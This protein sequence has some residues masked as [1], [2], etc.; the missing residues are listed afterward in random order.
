MPRRPR[1]DPL[2]P[3][4]GKAALKAEDDMFGCWLGR[5][6]C[7]FAAS[8]MYYHNNISDVENEAP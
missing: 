8:D 3:G 7:C 2:A 1:G 6:D 4:T 5:Q